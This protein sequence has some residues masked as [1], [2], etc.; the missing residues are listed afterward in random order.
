VPGVWRRILLDSTSSTNDFLK[1]R[2]EG[3]SDR[4]VVR[5]VRQT[6]GR[7]R[8]G[9]TWESP[10]GGLY[11]SFLL[12]PP[13]SPEHAS[14]VALL[15]ADLLCGILRRAG[16]EAFVKWP[17]DVIAGEGKIAGIL[18]EYGTHP[19]P[20]FVVGMGVNLVDAPSVP[21]RRGPLPVSWAG[22]APPP[23]PDS[24]LDSL[25]Q[26]LDE[27]WPA[28]TLDPVSGRTHGISERLWMA[29]REVEVVRGGRTDSGI[30]RGIDAEG[31]LVLATGSG[32]IML[33]S[34]EVESGRS[35]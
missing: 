25:L 10:P 11:A 22:F 23:D 4:T 35:V 12:V 3:L 28:R 31:R 7:G 26:V 17:N 30:V 32:L 21:G 16:I 27:A 13:P 1:E 34:G 6:S 14:R 29:G 8:L 2:L 15:L 19:H 24:L 5:A 9:R 20:W 18:P 33:D